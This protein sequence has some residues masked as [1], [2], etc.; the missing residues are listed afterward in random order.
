MVVNLSGRPLVEAGQASRPGTFLATTS[1]SH[2][3]LIV[4]WSNSVRGGG[5]ELHVVST[6]AEDR[7]LDP[8]TREGGYSWSPNR[9][10]V[11]AWEGWRSTGWDSR[12]TRREA[13]LRVFDL[14]HN[15]VAEYFLR[16]PE[17]LFLDRSQ[18]PTWSSDARFVAFSEFDEGAGPRRSWVLDLETGEAG[19]LMSGTR[20]EGWIW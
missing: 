5:S 12:A 2:T 3:L 7:M 17:E 4:R 14:T 19:L 6:Q 16:F 15:S 10:R 8:C 1:S 11:A 20:V 9:S 18:P 13:R